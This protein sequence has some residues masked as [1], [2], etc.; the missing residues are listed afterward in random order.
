[1]P[2]YNFKERFAPAVERGDKRQTIRPSRKRGKP[3]D[4]AHLYTGQR[5]K[6]CRKIGEGILTDVL[7]VEISRS[8]CGEPYAIVD[9][10]HI[11]HTQLD[12]FARSDGFK[13]GEE[14]TAWFEAQYGLPFAGYLHKWLPSN[15]EIR[16]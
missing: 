3:G 5:T 16:G 11:C 4:K 12:I 6:T 14:M 10:D 1:M 13:T 9:K 15:A 7:P 8:G 2:A